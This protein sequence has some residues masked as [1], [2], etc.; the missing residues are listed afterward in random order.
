MRYLLI[1]FLF[2]TVNLNAADYIRVSFD[3]GVPLIGVPLPSQTV[4]FNNLIQETTNRWAQVIIIGNERYKVELFK[5]TGN[6]TIIRARVDTGGNISTTFTHVSNQGFVSQA[7]ASSFGYTQFFDWTYRGTS[8]PNYSDGDPDPFTE[9]DRVYT[10]IQSIDLNS[11]GLVDNTDLYELGASSFNYPQSF[12]FFSD[13]DSDG[14][15][16]TGELFADGQGATSI[17]QTSENIP[18]RYNL[19]DTDGDGVDEGENEDDEEDEFDIDEKF[20]ELAAFKDLIGLDS[21]SLP[22]GKDISFS[23]QLGSYNINYG[24]ISETPY[25]ETARLGIKSLFTLLMTFMFIKS[26]V[27][28][29]RQ[30]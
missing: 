24:G 10:A 11:N 3:A 23:F 9:H 17:P 28:T 21:L 6:V 15:V 8:F 12:V 20:P 26:L 25:L 13:L 1:F 16:D 4:D 5:N 14:K 19:N 7:S 29:F 30:W 2:F 27:T 18:I 22:T